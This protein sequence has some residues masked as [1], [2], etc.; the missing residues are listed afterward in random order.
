MPHEDLSDAELLLVG[1]GSTKNPQ[2]AAPVYQHAAALRGRGIFRASREAFW[3]QE[4]KVV[5]VLAGI[6]ASRVFIVP[7]FVS[8]G[9]FSED[10]IPRELGFSLG[11][12]PLSRIRRLASGTQFYCHPIGT[13]E[14][15]TE[16]L[17]ARA[18]G[19]VAQH[20]FPRLPLARDTTLFVAG[21]GTGQN[22]TSRQ[23]IERQVGLIR[24]RDEY[25]AVHA[26]FIEETPRVG[27]CF[28]MAQTRNIVV[29]PFFISDGMHTQEDIPV[30]LGEP[31][32]MVRQRLSARQPTWRNPTG[33]NGK[34]VWYASAIGSEPHLADVILERVREAARWIT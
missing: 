1:H 27:A 8:E 5:E 34:L 9:Y 30:L 18:R 26:V 16:V 29:V 15:M 12:D 33:R 10:V 7:F 13:H 11:P 28:Q 32:R 17:L 14:S 21:H 2:S 23:A 20:P 22:E 24:R 25:A 3:I 6:S 31:E 4:P 19:V